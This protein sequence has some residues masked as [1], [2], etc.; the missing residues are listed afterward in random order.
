[1]RTLLKIEEVSVLVG[2]STATINNWYRFK[3]ENPDNEFAQMLP[4]FERLGPHNQKFWDKSDIDYLIKYK[5]LT[6]KGC[7][8]V[9]GS[10]TQKYV[11]KEGKSV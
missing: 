9:M 10:I 3:N 6:P 11:K 7:K 1:M 8:G 5:H 2:V 4:E